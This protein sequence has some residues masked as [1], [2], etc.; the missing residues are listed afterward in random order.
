MHW[1]GGADHPLLRKSTKSLNACCKTCSPPCLANFATRRPAGVHGRRAHIA[2]PLTRSTG[3]I[4][5]SQSGMAGRLASRC[6]TA[7]RCCSIS[8]SGRQTRPAD[9]RR[10]LLGDQRSGRLQVRE[11]H[12][13]LSHAFSRKRAHPHELTHPVLQK[14]SPTESSPPCSTAASGATMKILSVVEG[15]R[16]HTSERSC[17]SRRPGTSRQACCSFRR[18]VADVRC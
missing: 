9:K 3:R 12:P 13:C 5:T 7:T 6:S 14:R 18:R 11:A 1:K 16:T 17:R 10:L 15:R 8:S 4:R 2:G